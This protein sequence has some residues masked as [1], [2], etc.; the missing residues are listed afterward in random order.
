MTFVNGS[1][2]TF[3][4]ISLEGDRSTHRQTDRHRD[5]MTDFLKI[6]H[7]VKEL[8]GRDRQQS[9]EKDNKRILQHL[10]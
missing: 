5:S 4:I 1:N 2:K 3:E 7:T 10:D 8:W 9:T 6:P